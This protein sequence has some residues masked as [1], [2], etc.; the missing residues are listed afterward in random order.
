MESQS[1]VPTV[2]TPD[3]LMALFAN[4]FKID[5]NRTLFALQGIYLDKKR[6]SHRGYFYDR[7]RDE[8]TGQI[9]TLRVPVAIKEKLTH[10]EMYLFKGYLESDVRAEG[11]VEP[12]YTAVELASAVAPTLGGLLA[13]RQK[14]VAEKKRLGYKDVD[15]ILDAKLTQGQRPSVAF[16]CGSTSLVMDEI[17]AALREVRPAYEIVERRT[18]LLDA[19][20]ILSMIQL[21]NHTT[22]YDVVALIRSGGP[23]IEVFE[24]TN[25]AGGVLNLRPALVTAVGQTDDTTLLDEV[26]DRQF[27]L[28]MMLGLYLRDKVLAQ[29]PLITLAFAPPTDTSADPQPESPSSQPSI[30]WILG[31]VIVILLVLLI[32]TILSTT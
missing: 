32:Y 11:M 24:S 4:S 9:F 28:P 30:V 16:I 18:N 2:Y 8:M 7:V 22:Q 25:L 3:S 27:G 29:R 6:K 5:N 23:S 15:A 31:T 26:A 20:A 17:Y 1:T 14:I 21:H 13:Q 10:G 12:V 19:E